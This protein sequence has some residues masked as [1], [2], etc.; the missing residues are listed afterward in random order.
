MLFELQ[1]LQ[2]RY[3]KY[4]LIPEGI[5]HYLMDRYKWSKEVAHEKFLKFKAKPED[6]EDDYIENKPNP[7]PHQNT[8]YLL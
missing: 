8:L 3:A 4:V 5:E 1:D 2:E 6:E 7:A